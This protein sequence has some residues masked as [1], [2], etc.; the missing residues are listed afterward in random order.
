MTIWNE[1]RLTL[2]RAKSGVGPEEIRPQAATATATTERFPFRHEVITRPR[3]ERDRSEC[4]WRL[5]VGLWAEA[6]LTAPLDETQKRHAP[7]PVPA[8]CIGTRL[9]DRRG[10]HD[11]RACALRDKAHSSR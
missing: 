6:F 10:E 2:R 9:G 1:P 7:E 4:C 3:F 5:N 8:L 11:E